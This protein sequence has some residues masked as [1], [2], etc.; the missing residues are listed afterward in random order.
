VKKTL[1][2]ALL[3]AAAAGA[4]A[5]YPHRLDDVDYDVVVTR[6]DSTAN[7]QAGT[8]Y[9]LDQVVHLIPPGSS[10]NLPAF[11]EPT[12]LAQIR[13][14]MTAR[15]YVEVTDSNAADIRMVSAVS[16]TDYVGYYYDYWCYYWY[17]YCPP[18]WGTY[19]YT[20]GTLFVSMKDR[21]TQGAS[22]T[23]PMWLG[24]GNGLVQSGTT[25]QRLT[26]AI[27]QMFAQSPYI[28]AN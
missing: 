28:H 12:V 21:R 14:N 19:E 11:S 9:L 8:F 18:Y 5:G 10:D 3:I 20:V 26:A 27:D 17:Y 24:L 2:A 23:P 1:S 25:T 13:T 7:F 4:A 6:F 16:T 22:G 15:G